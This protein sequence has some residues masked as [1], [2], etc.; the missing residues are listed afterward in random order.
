M[1]INLQATARQIRMKE[2]EKMESA[3][4]KYSLKTLTDDSV[5]QM[6]SILKNDMSIPNNS[7]KNRQIMLRLMMLK[8]FDSNT[9]QHIIKYIMN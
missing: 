4:A 6:D 8:H 1:N 5:R 7:I 9:V 3:C 2:L